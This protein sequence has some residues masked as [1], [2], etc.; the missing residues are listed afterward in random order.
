LVKEKAEARKTYEEAKARGEK[1][2][3]LEQLPDMSDIFT[4]SVSSIPEGSSVVIMVTYVQELKHDAEVD[5]VRLTMP[6]HIAPRYSS[7]PGSSV[8]ASAV[9][10]SGGVSITVDINMA[11]GVP[12]KKIISPSH[13]VE[14]SLGS[15]STST[16]DEDSSISKASASLA[17]CTTELEKD[18]VLQIV[19]KD[20][21]IPQAIL[22]THP[23]LPAQRA[24]MTTLVPKFN[25][26]SAKP[27]IIFIADRSGSMSGNIPTLISALQVF[28]KSIPVGCMFNICSF[29]SNYEFL[30][31]KSKL[32]GQDTLTEAFKYVNMFGADFGGTETLKA[33]KAAVDIRHK[34]MPTELMLLTD[35]D[36]TAQQQMFDYLNEQTKSGDIRV[37]PIGIGGGV[38]SAL[39]EGVARAGKGFAQMVGNNEKLDGKMV[40]MLKGALT[41]HIKDYQLEVK[42][43]DDTVDSVAESL[44]L[45]LNLEAFEE[46]NKKKEEGR[47]PLRD[48][49]IP[50]YD[51]D[52]KEEHPKDNED[53]D[54]MWANLPQLQRPK[55]LQAPQ[56]ISALFP[57][58]RK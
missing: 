42:Y 1:A 15:L 37:F 36:I 57:F 44:R 43:E 18:F 56:E 5:G 14:V 7:Y 13:P 41:P 24:L 22:E 53:E 46:K 11:E 51:P 25:L 26:K 8:N 21:G 3:L 10:D 48:K 47:Y 27:E 29:G 52:V 54:D 6:T 49:P 20:I 2:A 9:N 4:T 35:G 34:D 33:V 16:I 40:R 23:T 30:W 38:S 55:L 19:A 12:I 17:L 58:N 39:I 50:L 45:K 32:Y 28:L 31:D